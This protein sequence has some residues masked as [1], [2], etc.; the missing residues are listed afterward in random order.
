LLENNAPF[1]ILDT[2]TTGLSHHQHFQVVEVVAVDGTGSIVFHSLIK[3]DLSMPE[4]AIA[5]HGITDAMLV[6]APHFVDVW[7]QLTQL[8]S[9]HEIYCYNAAFD[10]EAILYTAAHYGLEIPDPV[11]DRKRWHCMMLEYAHYRG[12]YSHYW[13]SW[14][15][16]PLDIACAEL[17]VEGNGFPRAIGDALNCLWIM[18][19]LAERSG[20]HPLSEAQQLE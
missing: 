11:R 16:Q 4:E 20:T 12:E 19:K 18:R 6:D 9:T 1:L 2:E 7:P 3:P 13:K 8:L 17:E 15:W 5:V 14:K 10:R